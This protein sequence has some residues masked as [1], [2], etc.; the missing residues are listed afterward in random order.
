MARG[1]AIFAAITGGPCVALACLQRDITAVV[2]WLYFI[3]GLV[4]SVCAVTALWAVTV[5]PLLLLLAAVFGRGK[6]PSDPG[7]P[8]GPGVMVCR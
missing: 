3:V 6:G 1:Y 7:N 4:V 8:D 2:L 5:W